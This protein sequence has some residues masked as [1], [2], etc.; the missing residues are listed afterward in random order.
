MYKCTAGNG[1][2][3]TNTN[4]DDQTNNE[5]LTNTN[6]IDHINNEQLTNTNYIDKTGTTTRVF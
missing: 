2:E 1:A 6:S 5:D 3:L 4:N